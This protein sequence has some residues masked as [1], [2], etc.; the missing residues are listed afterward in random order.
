MKYKLSPIRGRGRGKLL[1]FPTINLKIP[2]NLN[3]EHGIYGAKVVIENK[4]YLGAVHFGPIPTFNENNPTLEVFLIDTAKFS[5]NENERI[6]MDEF[7]YLR[8]VKNFRNQKD[9]VEQIKK[10]VE[11][12]KA[13]LPLKP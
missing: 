8:P 2:E 4:I 9:L 11:Q 5:L 6:E 13:N 10:D 7:K 12:I 1:G 3:L